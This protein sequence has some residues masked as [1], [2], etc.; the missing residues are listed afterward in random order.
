MTLREMLD[1]VIKTRDPD[2]I[3]INRKML[4]ILLNE[5]SQINGSFKDIQLSYRK[6]AIHT[7]PSLPDGEIK[8][9]RKTG[10]III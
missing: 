7:N 8:S 10:K 6:V 9:S 1:L 2:T 3:M 5:F 4:K